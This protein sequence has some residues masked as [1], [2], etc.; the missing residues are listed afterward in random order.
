MECAPGFVA[1][2]REVAVVT[3]SDEE[4][5]AVVGDEAK[6]DGFP[7][8]AGE[9]GEQRGEVDCEERDGGFPVDSFVGGTGDAC[10]H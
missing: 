8:D 3:R 7:G 2:V 1:A 9:D 4:H 10:R 6:D 5:A